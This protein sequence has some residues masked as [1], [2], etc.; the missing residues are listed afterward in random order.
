M[1]KPSGPS[2]PCQFCRHVFKLQRLASVLGLGVLFICSGCTDRR[3]TSRIASPGTG[4]VW[5]FF[6]MVGKKMG[7]FFSRFWD[8][9]LS[10][11]AVLC[12][13]NRN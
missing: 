11:V 3:L 4:N 5:C 12:M 9:E 7:L 13:S 8:Q 10:C 1:H 2:T 6:Q